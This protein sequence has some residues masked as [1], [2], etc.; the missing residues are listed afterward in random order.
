MAEFEGK[1]VLITGGGSGMGLATAQRLVSAGASVVLVGRDADRLDKAAKDLDAGD[2]VLTVSADVSSAADLDRVVSEAGARFGSLDGVFANAGTIAFGRTTDVTEEAFDQVVG[3]NFKGVFFTIAKSLPILNDGASIVV[4]GSWLAHKGL[5]FTAIYA[6]TKA[7]V[8]N[9]TRTL[10]PD[11]APRG[12]RVNAVSPGYIVTDMFTAIS[13]TE[14]AQAEN[15]SHVS[16][17]RLGE[18]H[19]VADAVL[20]LLS[21]RSS[22]ITGQELVVDGGLTT[23]VPLG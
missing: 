1:T 6:A 20:F 19:D 18:A 21:P 2:R 17:G 22:Y 13:S 7:A 12:I 9:L 15:R 16:L 3:T 10:S 4:N 8:I 11:L 23:S 5:A 14:E